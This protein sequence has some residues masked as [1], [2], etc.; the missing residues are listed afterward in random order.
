M[1][2]ASKEN[3][4]MPINIVIANQ[5]GGVAKTTTAV[6]VAHGLALKGYNVLLID[7]DPQGQCASLL[8]MEQEQGVFSL[9]V[10]RPPLRDVMRTTG[11]ANLFLLP[12]G[13]RTK[14]AE[15]LMAAEG[16]YRVDVLKRILDDPALNNGRLHTIVLDTAP[17]AGG[18]QENALFAADLLLIPSAVDHLALEGV[19]G[20]LT[21][22]QTLHR[23]AL[24][25]LRIIPTFFDDQTRESR[26]N[27]ARLREQFS[28][29]T[30]APIHRA[31]VLRECAALGRTIFEHDPESRAAREYAAIV[32]EV[33][34]VTNNR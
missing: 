1:D 14:S 21:T 34:N 28:D 26:T 23:P 11:R 24:P 15:V 7:L 10:N 3:D 5:K 33:L 18:L 22:L 13:K 6:T 17:S 2:D 12:G 25:L 31:T 8:D 30:L 16:G 27:L 9:L 19:A 29:Q 32:W 20:I 4:G